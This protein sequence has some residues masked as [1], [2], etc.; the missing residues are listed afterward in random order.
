[1]TNLATKIQ[2]TDATW[3]PTTG[4]TKISSGCDH[5]YIS[6]TPPF[7]INHRAF[8]KPGIGG[9]T[10][11][12]LHP[13]RLTAPLHWRTP[14]RVFV[15][16]LSD[17]FHEDV[18]DEYIVEVF[19]VMA[20]AHKH[21][22]QILTKRHGRMRSLLKAPDFE[23]RVGAAA[24]RLKGDHGVTGLPPWQ[25]PLHNVWL[26]VSTEDQAT[27][28][29]RIPALLETPAAIRF[30]SAEPLLSPIDLR[31][32]RARGVIIDALGGDVTHPGT[33]AIYTST[34]SVLDWVICGGESGSGARPMDLDWVRTIVEDCRPLYD[35]AV[36]VKQLGTVWA[37]TN[38]A[39]DRK[40]GDPAE[41]P[42]HLQVRH[43]PNTAA[44]GAK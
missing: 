16:S 29:L 42:A 5:C 25:W 28:E 22:F 24:Y 20:L 35:T 10:G 21:T 8:D 13:E 34:P 23:N 26:G 11:L 18:P 2:W 17:L 31:H 6:T 37:K 39:A 4:C 41:W 9:T 36:F 19:A 43:W 33:G 15:N 38:D 1:M 44:R 32:L 27:A 12:L 7:R 14:R 40:G 3:S 30:I